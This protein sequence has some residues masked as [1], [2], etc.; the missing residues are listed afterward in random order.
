MR[1]AVLLL[2]SAV[3]ANRELVEAGSSPPPP[4]PTYAAVGEC[5]QNWCTSPDF[6]ASNFNGTDCWAGSHD[7]RCTCSL[8]MAKETGV[9]SEYMV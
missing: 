2:V 9:Q 4:S 5:S 8:G 6:G 3:S 1:G 7:E